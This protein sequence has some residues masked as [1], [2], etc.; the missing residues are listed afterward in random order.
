[1]NVGLHSATASKILRF[2]EEV[3]I[4]VSHGPV[5]ADSFL[6]GI[7]IREGGLVIE[8]GKLKYTGDIL[9]EAG[10]LAVA[11]AAIRPTL[12]GE[13]IVPGS[14]PH[15]IELIAMLWSYA[16]CVHL[17]IDPSVVFH[18]AGYHG[19]AE[20]L[21]RNFAMGVFLG[22]H[23]LEAAGM[24]YSAADAHRLDLKPFPVMQKWLRD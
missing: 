13:V 11:P 16:A 15:L 12:N 23:E 6:P 21:L 14:D 20:S 1:M 3:R 8:D 22:I 10:H 24:T 5:A 17:E 9:H 18:D 4:R 19:R 7:E 2:L